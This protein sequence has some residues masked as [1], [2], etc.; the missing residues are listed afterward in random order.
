VDRAVAVGP[1][2]E[3]EDLA[4]ERGGAADRIFEFQRPQPKGVPSLPSTCTR[5][6]GRASRET[7]PIIFGQIDG[8]KLMVLIW[9]VGTAEIRGRGGGLSN[10][11]I[12]VSFASTVVF[13]KGPP[14]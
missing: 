2:V 7:S 3:L 8:W 6:P 1:C 13:G 9:T 10:D 12:G 11:F 5:S 4:A 14:P